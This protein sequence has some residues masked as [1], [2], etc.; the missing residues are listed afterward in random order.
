MLRSLIFRIEHVR[1]RVLVV[2]WGRGGGGWGVK[3]AGKI[4][5]PNA[6]TV[7]PGEK[8]EKREALALLG[9]PPTG[10]EINN[11]VNAAT[12]HGSKSC[13]CRFSVALRPKKANRSGKLIYGR[14]HASACSPLSR[15]EG[16]SSEVAP[17]SPPSR[18]RR[19]SWRGSLYGWFFR[20]WCLRPA[21]PPEPCKPHQPS[22]QEKRL[23]PAHLSFGP[24]I[25]RPHP[26]R[27]DQ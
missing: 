13:E 20:I 6:K 9:T 10:H 12:E 18:P 27:T 26:P 2:F 15:G 19:W 3:E 17:V 14:S 4:E 11:P 8:R 23:A 21:D 24:S 5:P 16:R 7:Y 1:F 25:T 22:L